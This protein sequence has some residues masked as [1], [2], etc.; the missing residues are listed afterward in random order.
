[1]YEAEE[2]VHSTAVYS[3][4]HVR[5]RLYPVLYVTGYKLLYVTMYVRW[6][7]TMVGIVVRGKYYDFM[8]FERF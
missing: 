3:D 5:Y 8:G 1:V 6:R 2:K 7:T 4:V